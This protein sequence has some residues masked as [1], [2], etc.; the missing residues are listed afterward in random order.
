MLCTAPVII[1]VGAVGGVIAVVIVGALL[2]FAFR[3]SVNNLPVSKLAAPSRQMSSEP[4]YGFQQPSSAPRF[5]NW[6]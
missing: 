3:R 2:Y 1:G 6:V 5:Y 4:L